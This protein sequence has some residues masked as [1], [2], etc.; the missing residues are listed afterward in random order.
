MSCFNTLSLH[1]F[2]FSWT[3]FLL[4][5]D[6]HPYITDTAL[7]VSQSL[8]CFTAFICY[9]VENRFSRLWGT[10]I[11]DAIFI[12]I[13]LA[14]VPGVQFTT[15]GYGCSSNTPPTSEVQTPDIMSKSWELRPSS[16]QFT[17]QNH[18]QLHVLV[19]SAHKTTC[20]DMTCLVLKA[21]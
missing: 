6:L 9:G 12:V 14:D 13:P 15:L 3:L 11:S 21:T 1:T 19:S 2:S 10:G 5:H 18:D 4:Q 8:Y 16:Q 17:V 7:T 20:C